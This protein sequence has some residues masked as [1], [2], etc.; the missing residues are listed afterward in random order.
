MKKSINQILDNTFNTKIYLLT[1]LIL[2]SFLSRLVVVYFIRDVSIDNEWNILLD[3]LIKYKS[4]SFYTFQDQ[5]ISS[6]LLPPA[7]PF[8]LYILKIISFKRRNACKQ[9]KKKWIDWWQK[10]TWY[11][12]TLKGIKRIT[13]IFN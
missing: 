1:L 5:L 6:A 2:L 9:I 8:F 4:Y 13:F 10:C 11:Q 12:L 7:Y 3:N